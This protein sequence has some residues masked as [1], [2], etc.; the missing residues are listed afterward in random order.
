[1][2]ENT[3]LVLCFELDKPNTID[4]VDGVNFFLLV[5]ALPPLDTP[6]KP[7]GTIPAPETTGVG[8]TLGD[9]SKGGANDGINGIFGAG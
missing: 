2:P 3:P 4:V 5:F 1:M 8:L 6:N 7:N 9:G